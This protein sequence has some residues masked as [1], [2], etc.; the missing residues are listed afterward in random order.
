M[1][2]T[3]SADL[4]GKYATDFDSRNAEF[5]K[6]TY[7]SA[8]LKFSI[9]R[10]LRNIE[11]EKTTL[12]ETIK[13]VF[14]SLSE[15]TEYTDANGE[16][17][18]TKSVVADGKPTDGYNIPEGKTKELEEKLIEIGANSI[19]FPAEKIDIKYLN[20][21]EINKISYH[22]ISLFISES[23]LGTTKESKTI[24]LGKLLSPSLNELSVDIYNLAMRTYES[25]EAKVAGSLLLKS[26][27]DSTGELIEKIRME[28]E[29]N[30]ILT[31]IENG[32]TPF[33]VAN[34]KVIPEFN[35][36]PEKQKSL[37]E[38]LS[39]IA[40]E[41]ITIEYFPIPISIFDSE[42]CENLNFYILEEFFK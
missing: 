35:V 20:I 37:I 8:A 13:S 18:K 22:P 28:I 16:I 30:C 7:K 40:N 17:Q 6:G 10:L 42:N 4:F 11:Q 38:A 2:T 12:S 19:S 14:E 29:S 41:D 1:I 36:D 5:F 34:K 23:F 39:K 27:I 9:A 32:K 26:I 3:K 33:K 25:K 31:E 21:D 24:K 15:E